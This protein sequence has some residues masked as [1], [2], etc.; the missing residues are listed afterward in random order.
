MSAG[1][2]FAFQIKVDG[3]VIDIDL[4]VNKYLEVRNSELIQAYCKLDHR[5]KDCALVL[6]RWAKSWDDNDKSK[7]PNSFSMYMLLLG[8]MIHKKYFPNLQ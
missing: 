4:L 3:Q 7:R 1:C 8:F 6:K 2:Q 5:F